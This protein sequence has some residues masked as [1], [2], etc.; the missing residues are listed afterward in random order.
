MIGRVAGSECCHRVAAAAAQRAARDDGLARS[1][2]CAGIGGGCSQRLSRQQAVRRG[3][4]WQAAVRRSLLCANAR[5]LS[6]RSL[7][8]CDISMC[9]ARCVESSSKGVDRV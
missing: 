9:A 7:L 6:G 1:D 4:V 5:N 3:S 8:S 2:M